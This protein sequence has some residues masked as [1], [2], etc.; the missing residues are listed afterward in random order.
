MHTRSSYTRRKQQAVCASL[1]DGRHAA[2]SGH[3]SCKATTCCW[4]VISLSLASSTVTLSAACVCHLSGVWRQ[5]LTGSP[6]SHLYNTPGLVLGEGQDASNFLTNSR[7][8]KSLTLPAKIACCDSGPN[9][10]RLSANF[11]TDTAA[12][13]QLLRPA[14]QRLGKRSMHASRRRNDMH[15]SKHSML[16]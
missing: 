8:T 15:D 12:S 1:Y 7:P 2:A 6:S 5:L 13:S 3:M 4:T 9:Q 11:L 16:Q 14:S 10:T